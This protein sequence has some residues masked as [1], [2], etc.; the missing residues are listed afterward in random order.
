MLTR[1]TKMNL[2]TLNYFLFGKIAVNKVP[3]NFA[4]D[5]DYTYVQFLCV[6]IFLGTMTNVFCIKESLKNKIKTFPKIAKLANFASLLALFNLLYLGSAAF[7]AYA[8]IKKT[9]TEGQ[10]F[11]FLILYYAGSLGIEYC[12]L[13]MAKET[14]SLTRNPNSLKEN[15]PSCCW[16]LIGA[17]FYWGIALVA[18]FYQYN[19]S[20]F[21]YDG[22]FCFLSHSIFAPFCYFLIVCAVLGLFVSFVA[23]G[24]ANDVKVFS[25]SSPIQYIAL[26]NMKISAVGNFCMVFVWVHYVMD[27]SRLLSWYSDALFWRFVT[28]LSFISPCLS[29][30]ICRPIPLKELLEN[31]QNEL[32]EI[33]P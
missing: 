32:A 21:P 27:M 11:T 18:M 30:S 25:K 26:K 15:P 4:Y 33:S 8:E 9:V 28:F 7:I 24:N 29:S 23:Q 6:F 19:A 10:C 3:I 16:T 1:N 5:V 12:L 20:Q 31:D 2:T 13:S 22:K 17:A 14:Y